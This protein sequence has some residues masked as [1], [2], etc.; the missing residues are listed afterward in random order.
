MAMA[1]TLHKAQVHLLFTLPHSFPNRPFVHATPR[2]I[3]IFLRVRLLAG[4]V[5]LKYGNVFDLHPHVNKQMIS[6]ASRN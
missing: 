3:L 1:S 6:W 4:N 5:L 2:M